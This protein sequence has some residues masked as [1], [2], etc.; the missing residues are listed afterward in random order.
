MNINIE[1]ILRRSVHMPTQHTEVSFKYFGG[2]ASELVTDEVFANSAEQLR[3]FCHQLMSK[4]DSNY[5][6]K[7]ND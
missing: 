7:S 3:Q 4:L 2:K 5:G 1:V 6:D